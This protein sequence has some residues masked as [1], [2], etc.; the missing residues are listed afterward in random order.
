MKH[1]LAISVFT[2]HKRRAQKH[3]PSHESLAR[4]LA[5]EDDCSSPTDEVYTG[6]IAEI[7]IVTLPNTRLKYIVLLKEC[8]RR[9]TNFAWVWRFSVWTINWYSVNPLKAIRWLRQANSF[10]LLTGTTTGSSRRN[11][12]CTLTPVVKTCNRGKIK[13]RQVVLRYTNLTA[14]PSLT[15]CE[16]YE[17]PK[18]GWRTGKIPQITQI[19]HND[20]LVKEI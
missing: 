11:N 4:D 13:D 12:N 2:Q 15:A 17:M 6:T 9:Q 7:V 14:L 1:Q 16:K 5:A 10:K 8:Y 20:I 3:A 19:V 18:I